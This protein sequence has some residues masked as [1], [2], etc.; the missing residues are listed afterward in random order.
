MSDTTLLSSL[1]QCMQA[2]NG[3]SQTA[4]FLA[5]NTT[6]PSYASSVVLTTQAGWLAN[7]E[8]INGGSTQGYIYN[9]A[10]VAA[11]NNNNALLGLGNMVGVLPGGVN[12]DK[13]LV[14]IPGTGQ[15]VSVTYSLAQ[16]QAQT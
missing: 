9:C 6:S 12:F 5:G 15:L 2:I 16:Q 1:L 8:M 3:L 11:I 7:V 4:T 13:G 10:T 14:L